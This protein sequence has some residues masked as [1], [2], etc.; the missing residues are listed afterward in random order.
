MAGDV[1]AVQL[2]LIG[3]FHF[4]SFPNSVWERTCLRNSVS[5]LGNRVAGTLSVSCAFS[6]GRPKD[7]VAPGRCSRLELRLRLWRYRGHSDV[8]GAPTAR[9]HPK[10]GAPP[11]EF[12]IR[13]HSALKARFTRKYSVS[14]VSVHSR[15]LA[16]KNQRGLGLRAVHAR[17]L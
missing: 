8:S 1:P 15:P 9:C 17:A 6:A 2:T 11:Q 14:L 7:F 4:P 3:V 12:Q 13:F 5:L 10:P 16:V